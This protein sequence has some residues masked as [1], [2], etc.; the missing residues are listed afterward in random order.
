MKLAE[1]SGLDHRLHFEE[2]KLPSQLISSDM[3][4]VK[5]LIY[6]QSFRA[7]SMTNICFIV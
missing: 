2:Y 3:K 7:L 1:N 5:E 6:I 4:A